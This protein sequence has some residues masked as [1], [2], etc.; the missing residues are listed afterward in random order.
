MVNRVDDDDNELIRSVQQGSWDAFNK[1]YERYLPIV[2]RR[3]RYMAPE[4]EAEDITQDIFIAVMKSLKN[5]RFEAQFSTWLRTLVN[6]QV[7]DFYRS[8]KPKVETLSLDA[9][10]DDPDGYR[11]TDRELNL[12]TED[13]TSDRDDIIILRQE[14]RN[15]PESYREII[16]L[17]FV[18]GLQ[19]DEIARVQGQSLE[20]TKSLFR[21]A[22]SALQKRI[23]VSTDQPGE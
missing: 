23:T 5:F 13:R 11:S 2:Y 22:I 3:V 7:A 10:S 6:R 15:L 1:L 21:R 17:R 8:R 14:L 19:F 9:E 12:S 20:A 18:D 16:M 4:T